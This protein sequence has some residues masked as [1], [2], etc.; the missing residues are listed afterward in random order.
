MEGRRVISKDEYSLG[1]PKEIA[2]EI[3]LCTDIQLLQVVILAYK[4][5][6]DK[7]KV[8]KGWPEDKIT[9][10]LCVRISRQMQENGT[11]AIPIHQYPVFPKK[12]RSG[13][14]PTIDFVFRKGYRESS[15]LAF[16]CKIVDDENDSSIQQ[17][18]NQGVMRFLTGKYAKN[19][20]TGGMIAYLINREIT[21]CV[22][23]INEQIKRNMSDS[24]CLVKSSIILDFEGIYQSNHMKNPP[25][26]RFLIY[27]LFLTFGDSVAA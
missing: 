5:L 8:D 15:Y 24:N 27:H 9:L 3:G 21:K 19:E 22:I 11:N 26:S 13:R 7:M 14:P 25:N 1:S 12:I 16:E 23:K 2:S 6:H 4:T 20:T 10:E 18:I 17:Y